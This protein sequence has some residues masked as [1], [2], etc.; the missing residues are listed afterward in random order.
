[1]FALVRYLIHTLIGLLSS[2]Y[3]VTCLQAVRYFLHCRSDG[4]SLKA[5][6]SFSALTH[7]QTRHV[8]SLS[9]TG[10]HDNVSK[11]Q[12]NQSSPVVSHFSDA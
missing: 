4:K 2:F 1:M 11:F 3:G 7:L 9:L 8:G 10:T 6:V 12:D 5:L